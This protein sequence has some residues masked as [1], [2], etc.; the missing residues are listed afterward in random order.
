MRKVIVSVVVLVAIGLIL[1]AFLVTS[2]VASIKLANTTNAIGTLKSIHSTEVVWRVV[3]L[4]GTG[5]NDYWT[6]DVSGLYRMLENGKNAA[7][8]KLDVAM[9][10]FER[11]TD[12]SIAKDITD[13]WGMFQD[14][15]KSTDGYY[16]RA[17]KFS[18]PQKTLYN[19]NVYSGT[20]IAVAN[21]SLFGFM[22]APARYG[23]T[24]DKSLIVNEKGDIYAC[25]TGSE[26]TKWCTIGRT[27]L[28]WYSE[29]RIRKQEEPGKPTITLDWP[30]IKGGEKWFMTSN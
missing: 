10:D 20:N 13:D 11:H 21:D 6:Y 28:L 29:D 17:M 24:A 25:D 26:E 1:G 23:Q 8:I 27:E 16:F 19:Q 2:K 7:Y 12:D 4:S 9:A 18:D 22:A 5:R 14:V 15:L 30:P 3:G